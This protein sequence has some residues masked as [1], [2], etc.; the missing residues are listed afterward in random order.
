MRSAHEA[1]AASWKLSEGWR[2]TSGSIVPSLALV[3]KPS[4]SMTFDVVSDAF[5]TVSKSDDI[6]WLLKEEQNTYAGL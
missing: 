1:V 3:N 2:P 6:G 5:Q 4:L